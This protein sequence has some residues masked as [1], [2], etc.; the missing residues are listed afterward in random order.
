MI[1]GDGDAVPS[2]QETC[3]Q[4]L[5]ERH[6]RYYREELITLRG[7][8]ILKGTCEWILE[9]ELFKQWRDQCLTDHPLIW[10]SGKT[11][12]GKT[13]QALLITQYLENITSNSCNSK[14]LYYFCDPQRREERD[15]AACI[16]K[17][18]VVQLC[19]MQQDL[20]RIVSEEQR[21]QASNL[22]H[23]RAIEPLWAVFQ[24]MLSMCSEQRIYCIIDGVD[25]CHEESLEHFLQRLNRYFVERNNRQELQVEGRAHEGATSYLS[26]STNKD[27][28]LPDLRMMI[29]S[30][31]N[32]SCISNILKAFS[33]RDLGRDESKAST[34]DFHNYVAANVERVCSSF[35]KNQAEL[36]R[37]IVETISDKLASGE[38]R[39][40]TWVHHAAE[41]FVRTPSDQISELAQRMPNNL[42]SMHMQTLFDIPDQ[43]RT[44]V[45]TILRWVALALRPLSTLELTKAVKYTLKIAF[46]KRN[47]KKALSYCGGT[48]R[49]HG[50]HI[51]LADQT[52]R[53][54]MF[55]E[56]NP[57]RHDTKLRQLVMNR[58]AC[59]S[60]LTNACIAYLQS[61]KNLNKSRRVRLNP[62]DRLGARDKAFFDKHP[63]L[64]YAMVHWTSHAQQGTVEGT[65]YDAEFFAKGSLRRKQWWESYWI[66]H[67][68]KYAWAWTKPSRFSLLHLAAFFDIIPLAKHVERQGNVTRLLGA[69]DGQGMRPIH[70]ATEKSQTAMMKFLL[71]HGDF[72]EKALRQVSRT[73]DFAAT[74]MLLNNRQVLRQKPTI[75]RA[76]SAPAL[77]SNPFQSFRT[78]ALRSVAEWSRGS[79]HN[80]DNKPSPVSPS[81]PGG[82]ISGNAKSETPLHIASACGHDDIVELLLK[83]G[84]D[85]H[86]PTEDGW[87]ALHLAAWYGMVPIM[88]RLID[89]G[90]DVKALTK[91]K[92][93]PLHCAVR[94]CQ[95][96]AVKCLLDKHQVDLELEDNDGATPFHIAC[97]AA[98]TTIMAI[99]LDHNANIEK[100]S[101]QGWTPLMWSCLYGD[102][103]VLQLLLRWGASTNARYVSSTEDGKQI[104]LGP[105][106]I[107]R[108]YQHQGCVR[109]L[110]ASGVT[111]TTLHFADEVKNLLP[112]P[113]VEGSAY[114]NFGFHEVTSVG[115]HCT[116]TEDLVGD[117]EELGRLSESEGEESS[118]EV[119]SMAE[120]GSQNGSS[121]DSLQNCAAKEDCS[122]ESKVSNGGLTRSKSAG[123]EK[124]SA[125]PHAH[126]L[127]LG[128]IVEQMRTL[129]LSVPIP[130][131]LH[132]VQSEPQCTNNF[133]ATCT[134]PESLGVRGISTGDSPKRS[135]KTASIFAD[136]FAKLMTRRASAP[137][138]TTQ[139]RE[140]RG[141]SVTDN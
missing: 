37:E 130:P 81:V 14:V 28:S 119:D 93:S 18:L 52:I 111:D 46:T 32:P 121:C 19:L 69:T 112:V 9:D 56:P 36:S 23:G 123:E 139:E 6:P 109:L 92:W 105:M 87:V 16:L 88:D 39:N 125:L 58:S 96:Q 83:H 64:E 100:K 115:V 5:Q 138:G 60:E 89:A 41:G 3:L 108:M 51:I 61:S 137:L 126:G 124:E 122:S 103:N 15:A 1:V 98:N 129:S 72:D 50:K 47:L 82:S 97:K 2:R 120:L 102:L 134:T 55:A 80:L 131:G 45:A 136:K 35:S 10:I 59:H 53:D 116:E 22:F 11:G 12:T 67:R 127:E 128:E 62:G 133:G 75:S 84:E 73:G 79:E 26:E 91:E 48:I 106:T 140:H 40:Y 33:R 7:S 38:G 8:K 34:S 95:P 70:W 21:G 29:F 49:R 54:L 101:R 110:E 25:H 117:V 118:D 114:N 17:G 20:A 71:Q 99:L 24:K 27:S 42:Q 85:C 141:S 74:T 44:T 90:A 66:S 77:I 132:Q 78:H 104:E 113:G 76:E 43:Q 107:A 135:T 31:E 30:H 63:F 68:T 86:V 94:N 13:Q 65:Y 4:G 57:F